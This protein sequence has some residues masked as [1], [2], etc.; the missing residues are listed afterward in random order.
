MPTFSE[1]LSEA[2]AINRKIADILRGRYDD[3]R[4]LTIPLAYFNLCHDHHRAITLLMRNQLYGSGM[5]LVR[6]IF[7]AMI[8]AHW[9]YKCAS[10]DQVDAAAERHNDIFPKMYRMVDAVDKAFSDPNDEPLTFFRQAKDDAWQATNSYTHS[11]LRQLTCQFSGDRVEASYDECDLVSGLTAAT[12]SL[13][14]L[15][16]LLARAS[17][18][19]AEAAEIETLFAFGAA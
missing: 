4:R 19:D 5:A 13:L 6:P 15:G 17:H 16:Y 8:K 10:A 7:E 11:G 18:R 12:A 14:M 3:D 1:Q 2:E 9:V